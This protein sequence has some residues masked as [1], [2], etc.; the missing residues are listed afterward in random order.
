MKIFYLYPELRYVSGADRVVIEKSNYFAETLDYEVFI[1]TTG[2]QGE[3]PFFE[4]SKKVTHIDLDINFDAQY[5]YPVL[6]R[7]YIYIKLLLQYKK[8]LSEI[9]DSIKP[10]VILS[11]VSR[12]IDIL[13]HISNYQGIKIV[14]SHLA[15]RYIRGFDDLMNRGLLNKMI[16]KL[17]L[18]RTENLIKEFDALV[19]LTSKDALNWEK[20]KQATVIPNFLPFLPPATSTCTPKKII[21]VGRLEEQKG[22]DLLIKAWAIVAKQHPD[23]R[24]NV[25]GEGTLREKLNEEIRESLIFESF[26]L[27]HP[28]NEIV[29]E[30]ISSSIFVLSS[31][32]EGFGLV[33]IEAMACGLP[34]IS[35]NCPD[36][37]SD[38]ISD[39]I[40][41]FLV[42]NGNVIQLAEKICLLIENESL[43]HTMGKN[44][45]ENVKRYSA[46]IIMKK[47][48]DLFE[49]LLIKNHQ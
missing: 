31:R 45:R 36:G 28:S 6:L 5:R 22:Y 7:A 15:K 4:L 33:L 13:A 46:E 43:R 8:K 48:I 42:D 35:F 37:P 14:E 39:G 1:I 11:T 23:W 9:I 19:V 29:E 20:I 24:I 10:D 49:S 3:K 26:T 40:D 17:W 44:A 34:V 27:R 2:Q 25:F 18:K 16:G 38:I 41:G 32:F 21:S 47:W 12:E 30:Y